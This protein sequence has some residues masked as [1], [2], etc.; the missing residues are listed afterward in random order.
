MDE[1]LIGDTIKITWINSGVTANTPSASIWSGSETLINSQSMT[2]SGNGH[3]YAFYTLPDTLGLFSAQTLVDINGFPF[4]R[5]KKF[6]AV[7]EE[8]D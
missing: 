2:D 8:V 4:K 6:R 1:F 7:S 3:L 5:K